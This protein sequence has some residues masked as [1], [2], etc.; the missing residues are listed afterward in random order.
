[1]GEEIRG[2]GG[3]QAW[4]GDSMPAPAVVHEH[5]STKPLLPPQPPTAACLRLHSTASSWA[6]QPPSRAAPST[7]D[8]TQATV[9][10]DTAWLSVPD[11]RKATTYGV[12][13]FL[14]VK[15]SSGD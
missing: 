10:W 5:P 8:A 1:M 15:V 13:P 4:I 11:T 2:G 6:R 3:E 14:S 7:S 12:R 9:W